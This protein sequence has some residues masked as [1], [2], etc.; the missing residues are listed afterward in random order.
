MLPAALFMEGFLL[1]RALSQT[2]GAAVRGTLRLDRR[3]GWLTD[4]RFTIAMRS[5]VPAD[6]GAAT[7]PMEFEM[8]ISQHLYAMDKP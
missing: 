6:S 2:A 5:R 1:E 7:G 3:R 4:S 8:R